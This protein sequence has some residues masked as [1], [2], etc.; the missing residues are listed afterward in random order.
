MNFKHFK[1]L[2]YVV[3]I[4]NITACA[5]GGSNNST[6]DNTY[7]IAGGNPTPPPPSNPPQEEPNLVLSYTT[8][9]KQ[10]HFSSQF[11]NTSPSELSCSYYEL[12]GKS[13]NQTDFSKLL[14]YQTNTSFT[15]QRNLS[16]SEIYN[17]FYTKACTHDHVCYTSNTVELSN[18]DQLNLIGF[19]KS[20]NNQSS[21]LFGIRIAT[22]KN[23]NVIAAFERNNPRNIK[24]YHLDDHDNNSTT[25]DSWQHTQTLNSQIVL[26][27]A[28]TTATELKF[29]TSGEYLFESLYSKYLEES[30]GEIAIYQFT[31]HD[32][33]SNTANIF[34][35]LQTLTGTGVAD[36]FGLNFSLNQAGNRLVV[37]A[38]AESS[39]S[40]TD[41]SNNSL[42]YSGAAYIF[43]LGD[44]DSDSATPNNWKKTHY[45]KAPNLDSYDQFGMQVAIHPTK[46]LIA[47]SSPFED[48]NQSNISLSNNAITNAGAVYLFSLDDHDNDS[49]TENTWEFIQY[50][51]EPN[52]EIDDNFGEKLIW[53]DSHLFIYFADNSNLTGISTATLN[54][55]N[56]ANKSGAVY[57]YEENNAAQWVLHS[58][59]KKDFITLDKAR[60]GRNMVTHNNYLYIG[61]Q[62]DSN[63]LAPGIHGPVNTYSYSYAKRFSGAIHVYHLENNEWIY[64]KVLKAPSIINH[65]KIGQQMSVGQNIFITSST[66]ENSDLSGFSNI[67][68]TNNNSLFSGAVYFY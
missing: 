64:K 2:L 29:S 59:I 43:E 36:W 54:R 55:N 50:I 41:E 17:K 33:N 27:T 28:D 15:L 56:S 63:D 34:Q 51:K 8:G 61:S 23:G 5:G 60:F 38:P 48:S 3:S 24:I 25:P 42:P 53:S 44:H 62:R 20:T 1:I 4:I 32:N 45:L 11:T 66:V 57:I 68:E 19:L 16:Q 18:T 65:A 22:N 40:A 30:N 12:W 13:D 35:H 46:N 6:T 67:E 47:I 39:N 37:G 58:A 9:I 14:N 7:T 21:G 49:S 10:I 26:S 52:P 31:D